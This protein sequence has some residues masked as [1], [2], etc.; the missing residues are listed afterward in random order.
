M[1]M[2]AIMHSCSLTKQMY[3][4]IQ[5]NEL[6]D[7]HILKRHQ[8]RKQ[9]QRLTN[10]SFLHKNLFQENS[11][12]NNQP[13]RHRTLEHIV[14]KPKQQITQNSI[15]FNRSSKISPIMTLK[16]SSILKQKL[17]YKQVLYGQTKLTECP[18]KAYLLLSVH[19]YSRHT[20]LVS[21]QE[22]GH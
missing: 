19:I 16:K 1:T 12:I 11:Q 4:S 5:I 3:Y 17:Q 22:L 13:H 21:H 8:I 10:Q 15:T 9:L 18:P 7:N 20:F 14:M 2:I 6:Q